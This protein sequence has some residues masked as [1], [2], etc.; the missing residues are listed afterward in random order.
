MRIS[1][2]FWINCDTLFQKGV[3][4]RELTMDNPLF[5]DPFFL[6]CSS[7]RKYKLLHRNII[8]YLLFLKKHSSDKMSPAMFTE[9]YTFKEINNNWLWY[10]FKSEWSWLWPDFWKKLKNKLYLFEQDKSSRSKHLETIW[11]LVKWIWKDR[12]SDFTTNL[13]KWFLAEYTQG[14]CRKYISQENRKRCWVE[15][16]QFDY[17]TGIREAKEFDLPMYNSKYILFVPEDLLIWDDLWINNSDIYKFLKNRKSRA[18]SNQDIR[19]KLNSIYALE[20]DRKEEKRQID[21]IVYENPFL[22]DEYI[23]DKESSSI[24]AKEK[25]SRDVLDL[26]KIY[27]NKDLL[28][29]EIRNNNY[30]PDPSWN[31]F[32]ESL[33]LI[34]FFKDQIENSGLEKAL[35]VDWKQCS[36]YHIQLIFRLTFI[37]SEFFNPPEPQ[38]WRWPAD[39]CVSR[40]SSDVTIIEFKKWNNSDLK[41]NLLNQTK[42]YEKALN[43]DNS[44]KVVF[45]FN[46]W[47][48]KKT[49]TIINEY[50][51]KNVIV[52]DTDNTNKPTWSNAKTIS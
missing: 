10:S 9:L 50:K 13:I 51:L 6:Y 16:S 30:R 29:D 38:T 48:I 28:L 14:I 39:F 1:E 3:F 22:I 52:V 36:E 41:Q 49:Q 45:C 8:E 12:I 42:T 40:W 25:W 17:I 5:I 37:W 11:L 4:D 21:K 7:K 24:K 23:S 44:I 47:E 31:S 34:T 15:K 19:Y 46:S 33:R 26:Q 27:D 43:I 2:Y 20:L 18:K 35:Y 32:Q